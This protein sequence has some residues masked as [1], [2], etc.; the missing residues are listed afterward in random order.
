MEEESKIKSQHNFNYGADR[1]SK[2]RALIILI[3][4]ILLFVISAL[5]LFD[6]LSQMVSDALLKNL[7]Y[8]N[9]WSKSFGSEGFIGI[10]KDISA[11]GGFPLLFIFLVII[12]IYYN[13]RNESR[14]LWRLLFIIVG[15]GTLMLIAKTIF[16]KEIPDDPIEVLTNSISQFPSGHAMMGTIFYLTLAVTTSRR[17]H[18]KK[19]K[20]LT[21]ISATVIIILIGISRILPG[22]HTVAE[23]IAGW[24]L[25]VI[26]LCLCWFLEKLIKKQLKKETEVV[27]R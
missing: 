11:L 14:R 4:S 26:W 21:L 2:D 24:S 23:V 5:G 3:S 20:K 10:N 8:T 13:I 16:A 19:T 12:I 9:K 15:G 1:Q 17:Q 25:G 27:S 22:S 18:S 7:G 6:W